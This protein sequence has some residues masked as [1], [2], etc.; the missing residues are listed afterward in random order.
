MGYR[1]VAAAASDQ[2]KVREHNEDCFLLGRYV[3]RSS[4]LSAGMCSDGELFQSYGFLAAVADGMGGTSGGALASRFVLE[5]LSTL[6]Y[7]EWRNQLEGDACCGVMETLLAQTNDLLVKAVAHNPELAHAGTTVVGIALFPK[8]DTVIFHAGDSRAVRL[9]A[10]FM[11]ALTRDHSVAAAAI[12]KGECSEAEALSR[13]DAR[14]LTHGM[15]AVPVFKPVVTLRH[16]IEIG[17]RVLLCSDGLYAYGGG[18]VK[19]SLRQLLQREVPPAELV[20]ELVAAALDADGSD[21]ITALVLDVVHSREYC[22]T[23]AEGTLTH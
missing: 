2:G 3:E 1:I 17:D 23:S 15:G 8:G 19:D 6:Y 11:D 4:W 7:S 5:T 22:A 20:A 10:G 18:V 13:P 16:R 14:L 21:N 12:E 9:A